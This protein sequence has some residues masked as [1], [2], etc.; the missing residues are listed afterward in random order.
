VAKPANNWNIK[1]IQRHISS[2]L[3]AYKNHGVNFQL[4]WKWNNQKIFKKIDNFS[5]L[6][7]FNIIGNV[8]WCV[9]MCYKMK[10]KKKLS[11]TH[12]NARETCHQEDGNV[13]FMSKDFLIFFSRQLL[14]PLQWLW[15]FVRVKKINEMMRTKNQY[16]FF[17]C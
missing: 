3:E 15:R 17:F 12:S 14:N 2:L 13:L 7:S 10:F 11:W 8:L 16:F 4:M 6:F 9:S 5:F 1:W